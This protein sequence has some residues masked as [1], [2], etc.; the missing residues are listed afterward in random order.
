M[1]QVSPDPPVKAGTVDFAE[2]ADIAEI[3]VDCVPGPEGALDLCLLGTDEG[4]TELGVHDA[5][6]LV[7][8]T[9][10]TMS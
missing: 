1:A 8:F 3:G 2:I 10:T 4:K 5:S 9:S 7:A 6:V